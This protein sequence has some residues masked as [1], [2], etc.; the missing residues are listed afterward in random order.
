MAPQQNAYFSTYLFATSLTTSH[1]SVSFLYLLSICLYLSL[2]HSS[3][4]PLTHSFCPLS[5]SFSFSL[6]LSFSP[7]FLSHFL[8]LS[9]SLSLTQRLC[10]EAVK[11]GP[12]PIRDAAKRRDQCGQTCT[13]IRYQCSHTVTVTLVINRSSFEW[14][15]SAA[16]C[17]EPM[18]GIIVWSYVASTTSFSISWSNITMMP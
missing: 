4:L 17:R 2:F 5:L 3:S 7:H 15:T 8:S 6:S 13:V 18:W 11:T 9:I 14:C 1:L 10:P 16:L 12:G